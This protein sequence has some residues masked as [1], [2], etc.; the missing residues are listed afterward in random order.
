MSPGISTGWP[1]ARY[2]RGTSGMPGGKARVAPLRWTQSFVGLPSTRCSSI[3]AM[4][5]ATS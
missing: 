3:L 5:W 1:T 4:L 2:A